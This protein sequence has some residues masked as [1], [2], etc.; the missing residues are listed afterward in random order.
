VASRIH[1]LRQRGCVLSLDALTKAISQ[2][3]CV[4]LHAFC[5]NHGGLCKYQ[6]ADVEFAGIPCVSKSPIGKRDGC[7]GECMT[8]WAAWIG[9]RLAVRNK[10]IIVECS[11][12]LRESELYP[13]FQKEYFMLSTV[14]CPAS[15]GWIGRRPRFWGILILRSDLAEIACTLPACIRLFSRVCAITWRDLMVASKG[16]QVLELKDA[17]ARKGAQGHGF[18]ISDVLKDPNPFWLGLLPNE[19]ANV[20]ESKKRRGPNKVYMTNQNPNGKDGKQGFCI[21]S[22]D[23]LLHCLIAN[24]GYQWDDSSKRWLTAKEHLIMQ[25]FPM[26]PEL[27]TP[28]GPPRVIGSFLNVSLRNDAA[29]S[30]S[31][32]RH[33]AG[34]SMNLSV[35]G[36]LWMFAFCFVS[37]SSARID[38]ETLRELKRLIEV[39]VWAQGPPN[40][41]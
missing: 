2:Q 35:C 7:E 9:L 24:P 11:D 36:M 25:G 32:M 31:A 5:V 20:L 37:R 19:A 8:S 23:S 21:G 39:C 18:D 30:R 27:S 33:Q 13:M 34:N 16:E 1:Q 26:Y 41:V 15:T 29:R 14:V 6:F 28:R 10:I 17:I 3:C 12:R 22:T 4:K 38:P 40:V